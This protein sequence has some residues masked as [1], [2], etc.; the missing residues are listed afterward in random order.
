MAKKTKT[1]TGE[2]VEIDFSDIDQIQTREEAL[3]LLKA[4]MGK[5]DKG[6]SLALKRRQIW[7]ESIMPK[8][9]EQKKAYNDA[10]KT[11]KAMLEYFGQFARQHG[12]SSEE[13]LE[14]GYNALKK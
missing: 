7:H 8:W 3:E 2:K 6:I 13:F 9:R 12:T 14:K 11:R 1:E 4:I 10:N 5:T